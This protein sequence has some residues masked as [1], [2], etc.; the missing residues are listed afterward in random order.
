LRESV[1]IFR[2]FPDKEAEKYA[3]EDK[4]RREIVDTRN[5]A[6]ATVFSLEKLLRD[7]GDKISEED[8]KSL[9]EAIAKA[10][11]EFKKD[12][13]TAIENALEELSKTSEGVVTKLYQAAQEAQQQTEK[14]DVEVKDADAKK[15]DE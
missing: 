7:N 5:K 13:K 4:A 14:P 2:Y 11:E 1:G 3:E 6:D 8:K 10:K 15:A 12:D 9:E